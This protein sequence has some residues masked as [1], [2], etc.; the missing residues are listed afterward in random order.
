VELLVALAR[1]FGKVGKG[2]GEYTEGEGEGE[3]EGGRVEEGGGGE[4]GRVEE[5]GGGEAHRTKS[6]K[7]RRTIK[8]TTR[9]IVSYRLV[10]GTGDF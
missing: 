1:C 3:G 2:G 10:W 9:F 5:G 7:E 8:R 6:R 4:G